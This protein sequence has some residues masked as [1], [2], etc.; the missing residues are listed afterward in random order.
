MTLLF[1]LA[2]SVAPGATLRCLSPAERDRLRTRFRD[3]PEVLAVAERLWGDVDADRA[4]LGT[5][6]S[7]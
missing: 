1:E 7:P 5:E 4:F 3:R 6:E 2:S